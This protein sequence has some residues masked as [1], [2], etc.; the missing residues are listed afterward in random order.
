MDPIFF[1]SPAEFGA[2]LAENHASASELWVGFWKKHTGQPALTWPQSVDEA[3]CYGW[4]DGVRKSVDAD[5]YVIRF[6]P[7]KARSGWSEVNLKRMGELIE[8]G[9]VRPAGMAAYEARDVEK[10]RSYSYE[11][12]T[13][14]LEPDL[15]ERFRANP[16]AWAFFS[17]QPPGYQRMATWFVMSGKQPATRL[18]RLTTLIAVSQARRRIDEDHR[19]PKASAPEA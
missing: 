13:Q 6:S 5:R 15:E 16:E 2:W 9:L 10:T 4:I 12:R 8:A 19:P 1:A 3:L 17:T 18:R 11:N 7:R 14:P